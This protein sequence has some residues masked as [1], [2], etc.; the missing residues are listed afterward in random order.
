MCKAEQQLVSSWVRVAEG[1]QCQTAGKQGA[2]DG[3][4]KEQ[5]A[6]ARYGGR[7]GKGYLKFKNGL[8]RALDADFLI[9]ARLCGVAG[10]GAGG[11]RKC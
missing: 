9:P 1:V 2:A 11:R 7:R 3:A 10:Q 5:R 8:G 6:E 4:R